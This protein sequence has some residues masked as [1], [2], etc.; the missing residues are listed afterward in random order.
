[1]KGMTCSDIEVHYGNGLLIRGFPKFQVSELSSRL[2][3][4]IGPLSNFAKTKEQSR[5]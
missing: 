4:T 3:I 2:Q 1:M 5:G